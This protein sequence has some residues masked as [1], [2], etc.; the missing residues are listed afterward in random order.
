[1]HEGYTKDVVGE[2]KT[3]HEAMKR[4]RRRGDSEGAAQARARRDEL[5]AQLRSAADELEHQPR[6]RRTVT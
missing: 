1:L 4:A 3:E 6:R 2:I 5:T